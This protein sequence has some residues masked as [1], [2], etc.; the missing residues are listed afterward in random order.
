MS[1]I[2]WTK[3]HRHG[4]TFDMYGNVYQVVV[5]TGL[6]RGPYPGPGDTLKR[7]VGPA[8]EITATLH[9]LKIADGDKVSMAMLLPPNRSNSG[10]FYAYNHTNNTSFEAVAAVTLDER[11]DAKPGWTKQAF[12]KG[13]GVFIATFILSLFLFRAVGAAKVFEASLYCSTFAGLSVIVLLNSQFFLRKRLESRSQ[14][15]ANFIM[16]L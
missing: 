16:R 9:G 4:E 12:G 2:D 11:C 10:C 15:I 14:Q 7:F 6:S 5:F 3:C 1:N 8:G 13:I